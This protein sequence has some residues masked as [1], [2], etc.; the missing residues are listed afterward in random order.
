MFKNESVIIHSTM[1]N[2]VKQVEKTLKQLNSVSSHPQRKLVLNMMETNKRYLIL[3]AQKTIKL[4]K[5]RKMV[6]RLEIDNFFI[7]LPKRFNRL[8]DTVWNDISDGGFE[9]CKPNSRNTH[10]TFS[11]AK[12]L[13]ADKSHQFDAIEYLNNYIYSPSFN[14]EDNNEPHT[15]S[16]DPVEQS[17]EAFKNI[18]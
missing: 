6:I 9:I 1:D 2:N 3:S 13:E 15:Q 16:S 4:N 17:D 8:P 5:S 7:Y 12:P 11:C 10:L 18:Q 14:C